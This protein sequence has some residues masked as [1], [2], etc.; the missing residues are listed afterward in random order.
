[1]ND[2]AKLGFLIIFL[3]IAIVLIG[4]LLQNTIQKQ[5]AGLMCYE[6]ICQVGE[7]NSLAHG[8]SYDKSDNTCICYSEHGVEFKRELFNEKEVKQ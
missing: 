6:D 4:I 8:S 3:V 1:M 2:K 5:K 7:N